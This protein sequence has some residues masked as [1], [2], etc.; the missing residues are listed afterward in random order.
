MLKI[1]D[2]LEGLVE[3]LGWIAKLSLI[4][5]VLLMSTNVLL[6][7]L[8][9]I[10]PVSLQEVEWHLISPI[11]LLGIS[12]TLKH[13]ADVRVDVLYEK[14]PP[15]GKACVDLLTGVLTVA[16]G[17]YIAWLAIPYVMQSYN[18]GE[19]SPDPGGLTHRYLLKSFI[20]IGFSVLALQGVADTLRGLRNIVDPRQ[21]QESA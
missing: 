13:R 9:S 2:T 18:F 21:T 5:L 12:Y 8:F 7:Y 16:V 17:A 6:R 11:A 20:P 19:K 15:R 14:F 3:W 1:I 4:V 10:S